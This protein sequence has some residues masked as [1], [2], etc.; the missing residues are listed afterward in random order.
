MLGIVRIMGNKQVKTPLQLAT[1]LE[2]SFDAISEARRQGTLNDEPIIEELKSVEKSL[3]A[4]KNILLGK[5]VSQEK[6]KDRLVTPEQ[7]AILAEEF[8]RRNVT[9]P[10]L[11]NFKGLSIDAK[12]NTVHI[13][14][15][16]SQVEAKYQEFICHNPDIVEMLCTSYEDFDYSAEAGVALQCGTILLSFI[17]NIGDRIAGMI[18][19]CSW[20]HGGTI[21]DFF[22]K[23]VNI[24]SFDVQTQAFN[25]LK[26]IFLEKGGNGKM[27]VRACAVDFIKA[28]ELRFFACFNKMLKSSTFMTCRQSLRLLHQILFDPAKKTYAAMINYISSKEYLKIT[29]NLLRDSSDQIQFEAFHLFKVFVLNPRRT[30]EVTH[31]LSKRQ[32][33]KA[34]CEYLETFK[35]K[36]K[37]AQFADEGSDDLFQTELIKVIASISELEPIDHLAP[38]KHARLSSDDLLAGSGPTGTLPRSVSGGQQLGAFGE[39]L[40]D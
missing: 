1:A 30:D 21:W 7:R 11:Q 39:P 19:F 3:Q 28:H 40:D 33:Q 26:D 15:H 32:N 20:E 25:T 27:C 38:T 2:E 16:L 23:Y 29:M 9:K 35:T 17:R 22:D 14:S 37:G 8:C 18:L 36:F 13:L 31:V 10:M 12:R 5:P 4:T 6:E 34:L 24:A